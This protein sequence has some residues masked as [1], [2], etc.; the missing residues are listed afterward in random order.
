M[1]DMYYYVNIYMYMHMNI[2]NI[3]DADRYQIMID[4][5]CMYVHIGIHMYG[6]ISPCTC[7]SACLYDMFY[8]NTFICICM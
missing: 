1:Y 6:Y 7:T 5:V 3:Q 8:M 4:V 2:F